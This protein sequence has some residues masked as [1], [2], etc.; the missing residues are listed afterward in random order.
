MRMRRI[1]VPVLVAFALLTGAMPGAAQEEPTMSDM[2]IE[3]L[4]K[5]YSRSFAAD[6]STM[7]APASP[8]AMPAGWWLLTTLVLE[9][10]SEDTAT[11]GLDTIREQITST[12]AAGETAPM[13]EIELD[14]GDLDYA[15][16][17]ADS[18]EGGVTTSML[19]IT[20]RDGRYVYAAVG[21]TF[22]ADPVPLVE[23]TIRAMRDADVGDGAEMFHEDGTSTGGL[24]D[25]LPTVAAIA[26][27][28]PV[29]TVANDTAYYPLPNATPAS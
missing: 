25:K 9:F 23:S 20:A 6:I 3:G 7:I 11:A 19:L 4:Q 14:L 15:A 27:D 21:L 17:R 18:A 12:S 5:M 2:D 16:Q 28:A 29:L 22:G 10:E 13:E 1:I 26:A 8:E 24:W